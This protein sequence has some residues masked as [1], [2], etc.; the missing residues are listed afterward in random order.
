[1]QLRRLSLVN[2]KLTTIREE[3]QSPF[4]SNGS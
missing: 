3:L 2:E 1:V 4:Q